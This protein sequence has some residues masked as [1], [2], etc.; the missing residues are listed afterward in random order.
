MAAHPVADP[1]GGV[2]AVAPAVHH[3]VDGG[4]GD[5]VLRPGSFREIVEG[6]VGDESDRSVPPP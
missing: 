1:V 5:D 4:L 6:L 3:R 2:R